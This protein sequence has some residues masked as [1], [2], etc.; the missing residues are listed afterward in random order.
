M[1]TVPLPGG[2]TAVISVS[3]TTEKLEADIEPKSIAVAPARFAPVMVTSVPPEA[4]PADGEIA[5]S[6]GR[7]ST[8]ANTVP[9]RVAVGCE[10]LVS[11]AVTQ[12]GGPA[13]KV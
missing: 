8:A 12:P 2:A 4:G 1:L 7:V 10:V 9:V 5:V 3:D 6:E 11:V 13:E